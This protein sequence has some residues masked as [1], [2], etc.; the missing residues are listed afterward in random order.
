M[1]QVGNKAKFVNQ[2]AVEFLKVVGAK[3]IGPVA[4]PAD[5]VVVPLSG[6]GQFVV[7]P[8][9]NGHFRD[10][11]HLLE[12]AQ[13]PVHGSQIHVGISRLRLAEHL[14]DAHVLAALRHHAE[15]NQPLGSQPVSLFPENF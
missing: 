9:A 4:D 6:V 13:R 14:V 11:P 12:E 1:V 5:H 8:V 10:Q 3:V 7:Q 15:N 2:G